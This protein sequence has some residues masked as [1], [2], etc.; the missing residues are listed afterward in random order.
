MRFSVTAVTALFVAV[1]AAI[2][3]AAPEPAQFDHAGIARA[4]EQRGLEASL[5]K[6]CD[7]DFFN[8]CMDT[9]HS[10]GCPGCTAGCTIGCCGST[11]C[12]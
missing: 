6:R 7:R 11:G 12:C 10:P 9:C 5:N 1:A 2:P 3:A 8:D 4:L